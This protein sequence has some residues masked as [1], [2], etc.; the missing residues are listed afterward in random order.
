MNKFIKYNDFVQ[1]NPDERILSLDK[2]QK[3]VAIDN[4]LESVDKHQKGLII[5]Y[6]LSHSGRRINN[7]IYSTKGQQKGIES[8]TNPYPKPILKNHNQSGEPIGRFIGGEW[9]SLN[10][11]ALSFLNSN[12]AMLDVHSAFSDDDP[13]KIYKTLKKLNL[14]ENK[15]WPGL[16]RMRVQANITDEEAIKKFLDG[17]YM[18]FSAGSTTDRHVCS[19]CSQDWVKDGMCEHRH[20]KT[21]DG[22]Q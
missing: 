18:T 20:G 22:A 6:D 8:L 9:Q 21:Y 11:D 1:I 19:I 10:E 17:R 2:A 15:K 5:T 16:G 14:I 7:R 4:L 13:D 12:Q 3:I